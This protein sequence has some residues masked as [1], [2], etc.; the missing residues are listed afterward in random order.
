[1]VET[2]HAPPAPLRCRNNI[3]EF[4]WL[5]EIGNPRIPGMLFRIFGMQAILYILAGMH[6]DIFLAAG[7]A[8]Y[9]A[10]LGRIL[11]CGLLVNPFQF[12]FSK[13]QH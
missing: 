1:M 9:P 13:L 3:V 4:L 11:V 2:R 7:P 5:Y 12:P 10:T 8:Q 6:A